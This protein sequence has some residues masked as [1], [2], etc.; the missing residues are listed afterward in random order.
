[1]DKRGM[2]KDGF[3]KRD[4]GKRGSEKYYIIIS[5]ILGLIV[6][7][8]CLYY[9][10]QEYF[11][12]EQIDWE[13]CRQSVI[14]R[15]MAPN[16]NELGTDMKG[17]FGLKCKTEVIK[18]KQLNKDEIYKKLA[19]SV[20]QCWYAYG[21][22][23]YDIIS[24]TFWKDKSYCLVCSRIHFDFPK[25]SER[26]PEDYDKNIGEFRKLFGEDVFP[27]GT[28]LD[29]YKT[30]KISDSQKTYNDYLPLPGSAKVKSSGT[31]FFWPPVLSSPPGDT[32]LVVIYR[33]KKA[34][35]WTTNGFIRRIADA[36]ASVLKIMSPDI[37]SLTE[38][39]NEFEGDKKI[40][41][42]DTDNLDK[43]ECSEFL[44]IP[45]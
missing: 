36:E 27:Y 37:K 32:D 12:Q 34:S 10:F 26:S 39:Q 15:S 40:V 21:E 23:N 3:G 43:A 9:I 35:G 31:L 42:T 44:T 28:F 8:L 6:L 16:L 18:I 45:A 13:A 4:F 41:V 29:Y 14:L 38:L 25:M 22:G 2:G 19:D 20:A 7:S 1:M 33:L 24:R 5:I 30:E 11:N 17:V